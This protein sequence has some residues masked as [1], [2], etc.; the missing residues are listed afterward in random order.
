VGTDLR[1]DL[2]GFGL[3]D[4]DSEGSH[5]LWGSRNVHEE[6][7]SRGGGTAENSSIL[8]VEGRAPYH[9]I[10]AQ[11][12]DA[13]VYHLGSASGRHYAVSGSFRSARGNGSN[14]VEYL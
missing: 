6:W 13:V 2:T 5:A 3:Y 7:F 14:D 1:L 12:S 10:S 9:G 8:D 4:A 11:A